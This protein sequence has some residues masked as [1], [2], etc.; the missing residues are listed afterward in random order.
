MSIVLPSELDDKLLQVAGLAA[1]E[2][3]QLLMSYYGRLKSVREKEQASLVSEA[4]QH[5]EQIIRKKIREFFPSHGIWG[6]E[7][8]SEKVEESD[9]IWFLDPLDG[10]TNYVHQ[11]PAFCVS[12][13]CE[14]QGVVRMGL[15]LAPAL[16]L[17]FHSVVGRGAFLNGQKIHCSERQSLGEALVVTG[18]HNKDPELR[19]QINI[20][21]NIIQNT[22]GVRRVGSA[23]LDLCWVAQG[24]FDVYWEKGLSPWDTAAGSLIATEAG[25][26]VTEFSGS[27]FNPRSKSILAAN[28]NLH[29]Q[30]VGWLR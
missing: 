12:I 6:E 24:V 21:E 4:D 1:D 26:T 17:R 7:Y 27:K 23:A 30:A 25:A 19:K 11:F 14:V 5:A 8:G 28:P 16:N 15:V 2:A 10:T 20:L 3:S 29:T 18:F 13:G 22:R 9:V